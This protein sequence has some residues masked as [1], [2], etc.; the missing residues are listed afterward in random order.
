MSSIERND[1]VMNMEQENNSLKERKNLLE[2]EVK[3]METKLR[4]I[5]ALMRS[6][7][8]LGDVNYDQKDLQKDLQAEFD[9]LKAQNEFTKEKVR[10]LAVI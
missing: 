8:N 7:G 2:V 6:R 4:R 10:K 3:K 5:E 9:N 1:R